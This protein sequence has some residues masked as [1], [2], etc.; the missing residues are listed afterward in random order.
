[1]LKPTS[2]SSGIATPM[3]GDC[4][5]AISSPMQVAPTSSA[6]PGDGI[7]VAS[8][9]TVSVPPSAPTPWAAFSRP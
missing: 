4:E 5:N 9:A 6:V 8:V 2:A 7:R 3:T 1:L